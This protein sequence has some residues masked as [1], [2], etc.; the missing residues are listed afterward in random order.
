ML[1]LSSFSDFDWR[2]LILKLQSFPYI[3]NFFENCA[4][5]MKKH[6]LRKGANFVVSPYLGYVQ[7]CN[8]QLY[9]AGKTS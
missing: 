9:F 1:A 5:A 3:A 6:I 8:Y 2:L 7:R 4:R